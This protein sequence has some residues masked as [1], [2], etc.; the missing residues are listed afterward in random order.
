MLWCEQ[1][2]QGYGKHLPSCPM[3]N[4]HIKSNYERGVK[5]AINHKP[6]PPINDYEGCL[7]WLVKREQMR[8]SGRLMQPTT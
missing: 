5:L 3:R 8:R 6:C 2:L 7:G 4:R 1:C